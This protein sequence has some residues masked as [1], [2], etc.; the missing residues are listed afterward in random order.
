MKYIFSLFFC[1]LMFISNAQPG[2][3]IRIKTENIQSDSLFIKSYNVKDKKFTNF[4]VLKFANDITIKD[5]TPL[6]AGIYII[7]TDS[8]ILSEFLISDAKNQ[9]F[10]I[11][12]SEDDVNVEGSKENSAN[13]TYMKQ[14]M[15]FNQRLRALNLEFQQ[16]QQELPNSM[17][18]VYVDSFM[19][20][21]A[22]INNEKKIYQEK[23]ILENKGTLLATI[24][25]CSIEVP[26]P[27]QEYYRDQIKLLTYLSEHHF[28]SFTWDDERL[29]NTPVL[30]QHFKDFAQQIFPLDSKTTIPIV[31]KTLNESKKNR[32]LYYAF[33]DFIE[34]EFGSVKSLYRDELLYI[35][36]LKD[37]LSTTDLEETRQPRYE[38]ELGL[39]NKNHPGDQAIDFK[40]LLSDGDTTSLY[41]IEAEILILY[42]QNPDCP[43]CKEFREKMKNMEVLYHAVNSGKVKVLTLYFEDKEDLW[44]NYLEKSAF[45]NWMHGWNYDLQIS[46]KHLYDVRIIPTIMVLDKNKKIVEKDIFPNDL[47]EWIRKNL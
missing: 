4:L 30:Y 36:M 32:K 1:A 7:E 37:I 34:H 3:Q 40:I 18:Q 9:K 42:F 2:Y 38:Y 11:S 15:E 33:F 25:Q 41:A 28:D 35:A 44:R 26:M 24:I 19:V 12:I 23:M 13:R 6:D 20:K 29:L 21:L 14:M 22:L 43:T 46:E 5:K 45:K 27:P 47:E 31:L 17:M 39:I 10:T 16:M 8:A